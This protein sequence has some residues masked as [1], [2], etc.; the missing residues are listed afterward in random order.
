MLGSNV[1]NTR[2]AVWVYWAP[3]VFWLAVLFTESVSKYAAADETGRFIVPILHWLLPRLSMGQI[4][5]L[6][7]LIRKTGHFTGY[8]LLSYFLFRAWRGMYHVR[9]GTTEVL[10]RSYRRSGGILIFS[11]NWRLPWATLALLGTSLVAT[12]DEVHQMTLR[13]R[14]GSW[15][16]VLLDSI[17]GLIFQFAILLYWKW[18]VG[19][20]RDV[21]ARVEV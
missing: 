12:C 3:V 20:E 4:N 16:D 14:T 13:N 2:K 6:H 5:T 8:G 1:R 15:W 10:T 17:G 21:P 11:E 7:E 19:V 9:N 18:R